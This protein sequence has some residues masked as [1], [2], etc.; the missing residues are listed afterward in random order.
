[1]PDFR[2]KLT[3]V[4]LLDGIAI[5]FFEPVDASEDLDELGALLAAEDDSEKN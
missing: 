3:G 2:M 1:M 4:E 5:G